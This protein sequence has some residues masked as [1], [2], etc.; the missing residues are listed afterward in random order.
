VE[1]LSECPVRILLICEQPDV[2]T[3]IRAMLPSPGYQVAAGPTPEVLPAD[4]PHIILMDVNGVPVRPELALGPLWEAVATW[5]TPLL[6]LT[7][8]EGVDRWLSRLEEGLVD[9]LTWPFSPGELAAR[10]RLVRRTKAMFDEARKTHRRLEELSITDSLTG[11]YNG[12]YLQRR[13]REEVARAKRYQHPISCIM[14]DVDHFKRINDAHGHPGGNVVLAELG[15]VLKGVI[16][17]SDIAGRFGG[18]EFLLI[19]PET[20]GPDAMLLA[21]RLRGTIERHRFSVG[22]LALTITVSVGVATFPDRGISGHETLVREADQAM[23]QAKMGG[24]NRVAGGRGE[25]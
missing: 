19:L 8:R 6:L 14:V 9:Y 16:R 3:G 12:W 13:C 23:Y 2:V 22:D 25:G 1:K 17:G 24:R 4:L 21:E 18:E 7:A 5:D 10:I 20:D 15:K 11:L